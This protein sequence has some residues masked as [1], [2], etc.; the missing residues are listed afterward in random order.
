[1]IVPVS[2]N[3]LSTIYIIT[4]ELILPTVL[5]NLI[6]S[7]HT[8]VNSFQ[9][10]KG[11]GIVLARS[12]LD[13]LVNHGFSTKLISRFSSAVA[14]VS[15]LL[16][17]IGSFS[18]DGLSRPHFVP[19][20]VPVITTLATSSSTFLNFSA[21]ISIDS[22]LVSATFL[23]AFHGATCNLSNDKKVDYYSAFNNFIDLNSIQFDVFSFNNSTC[24][25]Q[26]S[27]YQNAILWTR[28]H[29]AVDSDFPYCRFS[30]SKHIDRNSVRNVSINVRGCKHK[31]VSAI[32][33]SYF[34]YTT[35][36][37]LKSPQGY[38]LFIS[39]H[40]TSPENTTDIK[41]EKF[42]LRNRIPF[43]S[44]MME[45]IAFLDASNAGIVLET[46]L[47]LAQTRVERDKT[48]IKNV[49]KE[50]ASEV[51][52]RLLFATAGVS[53]GIVMAVA[54]VRIVVGIVL[55][56]NEMNGLSSAADCMTEAR[57]VAGEDGGRMI[58]IGLRREG[59]SV[60]PVG[61]NDLKEGEMGEWM[62][63]DEQKISGRLRITK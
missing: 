10:S 15:F 34:F 50:M 42:V 32:A 30:V 8:K 24:V 60:G 21:H 36:V 28:K 51:N 44:R 23:L 18:I 27:G 3:I 19:I 4:F 59:W 55:D 43:H 54:F 62:S 48:V 33:A 45:S 16:T 2:S 9:L 56:A 38:D 31:F 63:L 1:M 47:V 7:V 29:D 12:K 46:I 17:L 40:S 20:T 41:L 57:Y 25:R 58:W 61:E 22:G 52:L 11:P 6:T 49:G 13:Y 5:S 26:E 37:Q 35:V 39:S 14:V 53:L